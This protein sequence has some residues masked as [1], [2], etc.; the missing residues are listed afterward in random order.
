MRDKFIPLSMVAPTVILPVWIFYPQEG[1]THIHPAK[2]EKQQSLL[3]DLGE[4]W[5]HQLNESFCI[6]CWQPLLPVKDDGWVVQP[7]VF[8]T[9]HDD[10]NDAVYV[11]FCCH[12][13]SYTLLYYV[14]VVMLPYLILFQSSNLKT[15]TWALSI[16]S[17][18]SMKDL[19]LCKSTCYFNF[20]C[21]NFNLSSF[22]TQIIILLANKIVSSSMNVSIINKYILPEWFNGPLLPFITFTP[23]HNKHFSLF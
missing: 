7:G 8:A 12:N 21:G 16:F 3:L 17:K 9:S 11:V 15:I 5:V 1:H 14:C 13:T 22:Y 10:K 23:F 20:C 4:L 18:K 19:I 6:I 2:N